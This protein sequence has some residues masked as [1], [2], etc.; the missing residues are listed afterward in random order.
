[1]HNES[2]NAFH[3]IF[4]L[5]SIEILNEIYQLASSTFRIGESRDNLNDLIF[6]E[7]IVRRRSEITREEEQWRKQQT[8]SSNK[9]IG[10]VKEMSFP[11]VF[12]HDDEAVGRRGG[13]G[14][15]KFVMSSSVIIL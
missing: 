12:D 9:I 10:V 15:E 1:M 3:V 6:L 14:K 5:S 11:Y 13:G 7:I 8:P 2:R 4:V